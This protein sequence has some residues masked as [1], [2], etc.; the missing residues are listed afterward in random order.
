MKWILELN[1]LCLSLF[2]Y[3]LVSPVSETIG[4]GS[5]ATLERAGNVRRW[6]GGGVWKLA[7]YVW[8]E[9]YYDS[10]CKHSD[11]WR[12]AFLQA[13]FVQGDQGLQ[14][15]DH[16]DRGNNAQVEQ[17]IIIIR[18]YKVEIIFQ[19]NHNEIIRYTFDDYFIINSWYD[20]IFK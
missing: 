18:W 19:N 20:S 3:F 8:P 12:G 10:Q 14:V 16:R 6:E 1:R 7:A 15:G 17:K 13:Y 2:W 11:G 5:G 4:G 9:Q